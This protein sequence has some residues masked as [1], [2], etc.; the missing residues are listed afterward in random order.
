ML[1]QGTCQKLAP[2][3]C[4]ESSLDNNCGREQSASLLLRQQR[5][6][7]GL[8]PMRLEADFELV[9][10]NDAEL[11]RMLFLVPR[12]EILCRNSIAFEKRP[13][14][15][16]IPHDDGLSC[17]RDPCNPP[18]LLGAGHRRFYGLLRGWML[19]K[20]CNDQD[21]SPSVCAGV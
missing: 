17:T 14:R 19:V 12:Q 1:W 21:G 6:L 4:C 8:L 10:N 3:S 15:Q 11:L 9:Q 20:W 5:V 7:P 18:R 2:P 13:A 16:Q